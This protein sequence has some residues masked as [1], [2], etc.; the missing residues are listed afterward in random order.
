KAKA[1]LKEAGFPNGLSVEML[2]AEV[3]PGNVEG[4]LTLQ[5]QVKEAGIDMSVKKLPTGTYFT[6]VLGKPLFTDFWL[7]QNVGFSL[8]LMYGGGSG[9]AWDESAFSDPKVNAAISRMQAT[10]DFA[11]QKQ[12]VADAYRVI[13]ETA[14]ELVPAHN[15]RVWVLKPNLKGVELDYA[16]V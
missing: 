15:D 1:L 9:A 11:E 10:L 5:Q 16:K 3:S 4:A 14:G 2:T 8:P 12:A 6:Q 7:R 13:N